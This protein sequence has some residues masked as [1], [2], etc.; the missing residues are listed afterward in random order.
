MSSTNQTHTPQSFTWNPSTASICFSGSAGATL[1][2]F[3][4]PQPVSD[5]IGHLLASA[6]AMLRT[7][8]RWA[9]WFEQFGGAD[10]AGIACDTFAA[11]RK[12]KGE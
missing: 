11:I 1:V 4:N 8:E 12:A 3:G 9:R 7:L 2:P 5:D 6:P 10:V